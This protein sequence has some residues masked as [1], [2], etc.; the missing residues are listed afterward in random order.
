MWIALLVAG[1]VLGPVYLSLP[2][3]ARDLLYAGIACLT[4]IVIAVAIAHYRPRHQVWALVGLGAALMAAGE[5]AWIADAAG[6]GGG[7][8]AD[9]LFLLGYVPLCAAMAGAGRSQGAGI[10][11]AIDAAILS[12]AAAA[13]MWFLVV[14]PALTRTDLSLPDAAVTVAYPLADL[15]VLGFLL[16]VV[17]DRPRATPSL[18]LFAVGVTTFLVADIAYSVLAARDA[19]TSGVVDLG[20]IAGYLLWAAAA[21][22]PSMTV[23]RGRSHVETQIS[24]RRLA[25][26]AVAS[27]VPLVVAASDQVWDS[28][29]DPLPAVVAS[30]VM[31]LLV[32]AR[33][34]E[35]VRD[36]RSLIDERARMQ[37]ELERMSMEDALTGLANRR[38]FGL[39]LDPS[40]GHQDAPAAVMLLDL[41]DFKHIND[42]LGHAAGD[43]VLSAVGRRLRGAVRGRD[44]VARLGGDEFAILMSDAT[45][46]GAAIALAERLLQDIREPIPLGDSTVRV[47]ASVGIAVATASVQDPDTLMRNADLALYRAKAATGRR[48]EV[49]DDAIEQESTRSLTIRR[50]LPGAVSRGELQL[51]YQP[52]VDPASTRPVAVEALLRWHHPGLGV[53]SPSEFMH[54]AESSGAMPAIGAWM[55]E[56]ACRAVAGWRTDAGPLRLN[57]NL[58]VSQLR[59]ERLVDVVRDAIERSGIAPARLV[60]EITEAMLDVS[61]D[62]RARLDTLCDLGVSLAIDDFGTGYSSLARVAA[63]PVRELK[64]DQSL[65]GA[66]ARLLGAVRQFGASLGVRVVMEGVEDARDLALVEPL[67]FDG[68]QGLAVA[69]P[70]PAAGIARYLAPYHDPRPSGRH[71]RPAAD[72]GML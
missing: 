46:Q 48:I 38:G 51:D 57:L 13:I 43:A 71:W 64:V 3:A 47:G 12:V 34:T 39:R 58:A 32:V 27:T 68:I 69:G 56:E 63:L 24:N 25:A 5:L 10:G 8:L 19:Y 50:S 23:M 14:G 62:V 60:L 49:F 20:W 40:R 30:V 65:A 37:A 35:L 2:A 11:P 53:V 31:F 28:G 41:D 17:L 15:L 44:T 16:R 22:H 42:T 72:R 52:I 7:S 70:M 4:P 21:C 9:P 66:D 33:L 55:L 18:G 67:R 1:V 29:V 45:D 54:R 36:Q 6:L 61:P 59:D 26:L